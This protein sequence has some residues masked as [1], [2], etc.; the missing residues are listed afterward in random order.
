MLKRVT[1]FLISL[2]FGIILFLLIAVYSIIG[3]IVPQGLAPDH[4]PHLYRTFGRIMLILQF[5]NIYNSIIF[6]TIVAIFIVNLAGCTLNFL[7][8]Q[9]KRMKNT[10]TP[11]PKENSENLYE[12]DLELE[13]LIDELKKKRFKIIGEG[14][15]FYAVK[16]RIGYLG[17]TVTHIG[18]IVI[19]LGGFIGNLFA[20]EGSVSLLPGQE[21]NFPDHNFSIVVDDFYIEF[22]EDNSIEQYISEVSIY[23]EGVK[24][25]E[26][27]IWVNNPL[28]HNG[29]N[30]YQSY[31]GWLNKIK[32]TDED[33]NLLCDSL[34][35][36]GQEHV[37]EAGDLMVFLYGFFPDFSMDSMGNPITRSQKIINPRYAVVLHE[38]GQY[39]GSYIVEPGEEMPYNN[40]KI[41]FLEPTL[42]TGMTYRQDYGYYF[43]LAGCLLVFIGLI[44]SFYLYP[45]YIYITRDSVIPITKQNSWGFTYKLKNLLSEVKYKR[46]EEV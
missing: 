38:D 33:G 15:G 45:K 18:I 32:I 6:R 4:Y 1:N 24:V 16:D 20:I 10:Y 13:L 34:I 19:V 7:P 42:Y 35:G 37:Y 5:D 26:E 39:A 17:S 41:Q 21:M 14:V 23:E 25:K 22:R 46:G 3:T 27:K 28:L 2:K 30:L 29:L 31:Y 8:G 12:G 40:L 9:L 36:D 44:L 11:K 43:V